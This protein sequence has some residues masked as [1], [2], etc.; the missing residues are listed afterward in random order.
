MDGSHFYGRWSFNN[1]DSFFPRYGLF[2]LAGCYIGAVCRNEQKK[3][4]A[5]TAKE[6]CYIQFSLHLQTLYIIYFFH[7]ILIYK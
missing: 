5:Y 1:V 3:R 7:Y 4:Q 6:I 2:L